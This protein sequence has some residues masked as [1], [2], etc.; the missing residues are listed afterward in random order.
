V[1]ASATAGISRAIPIH[2]IPHLP[3][4]HND[5]MIVIGDAAHAPT[6]TSG[7]GASLSIE[8]AVVLA[9]CLRD[10]PTPQQAFARFEALR[11]PRSERII[12]QA[13]RINSSKTAGPITRMLRDATLPA[14]MK[15]AAN[16]KQATAAYRYHIDWDAPIAA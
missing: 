12:K 11:R 16:S 13:A 1:E 15:I 5:R 9:Q 4:W 14:I 8:D 6:P 10:L 7:Q 3:A 2:S